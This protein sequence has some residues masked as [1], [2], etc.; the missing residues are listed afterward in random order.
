MDTFNKKKRSW[1]MA[2]VK[3]SGNRSTEQI[4]LAVLRK[5]KII[6]W[7]RH[8]PIFGNPDFAFPD[9]KVAVFVDGCFWHG[10]PKKCRVPQSNREYW[11][12]KISR[13]VSRDKLVTRT[14][15]VKGWKV[16]RI[17]EDAVAKPSTV[18]RLRKVIG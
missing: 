13:N 7:R 8:Y 4:L 10:H 16:V 9:R 2:Q 5:S 18:A 3:S 12:N 14:L 1:I 17:W 11:L 15:R 6:G